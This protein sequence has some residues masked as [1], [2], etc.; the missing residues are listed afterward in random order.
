LLAYYGRQWG[1][2]GNGGNG[3]K[4]KKSTVDL[5]FGSPDCW[6]EAQQKVKERKRKAVVRVSVFEGSVV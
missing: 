2:G 4:K 6:E 5:V 1:N 3:V